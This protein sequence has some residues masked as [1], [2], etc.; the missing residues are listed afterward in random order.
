MTRH[1]MLNEHL[2]VI[3]I[4]EQLNFSKFKSKSKE[5]GDAAASGNILNFKRVMNTMPDFSLDQLKLVARKK[6]SSN[7]NK[8]EKYID[9]KIKKS[10]D[11]IKDVMTL[12]RSS[13]LQ[14]KSETKD[15]D[16]EKKV[17]E[18]LGRL[19]VILKKIKGVVTIKRA[20]AASIITLLMGILIY[21]SMLV[22]G[23]GIMLLLLIILAISAQI[24]IEV[25]SI[26]LSI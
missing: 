7:Y 25:L 20:V 17:D 12:T 8:S 23:S 26:G 3:H 2:D 14:V 19:D 18:S 16:I 22:V 15:S 5:I 9:T 11:K 6:F 4:I 13:L 21:L 1:D 24:M 10:P